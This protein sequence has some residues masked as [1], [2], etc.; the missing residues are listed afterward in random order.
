LSQLQTVISTDV[1]DSMEEIEM[2]TQKI[3][4]HLSVRLYSD[5]RPSCLETADLQKGLVLLFDGKELIEEGVGFGVPV[6]KY[7]DKT[8]FPGSAEIHVKKENS[9][10]VLTKTYSLNTVSLKKFGSATYIDDTLYSPLRKTFQTLYL[11]H[12]KLTPLFNKLME[13]RE[14]ANLK[15]EFIKVKPRG[16][17]TVSYRCLPNEIEVH[18]DFSNLALKRC[19]EILVLNEQGASFFPKYVDSNGLTLFGQKIGAW[20]TV[21]AK[22][23]TLQSVKGNVSFQLQNTG[24][25]RLFRGF[26]HTK[27]RFSWVGLSYSM[28]PHNR[29]FDYSVKLTSS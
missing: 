5:C 26:E 1:S 22:Q 28:H 4:A 21:L 25:A 27:K 15:T 13:L 17:V 24:G 9:E 10:V 2:F 3:S 19:S 23:S 20:E 29:T 16:Q 18:A 12:K 14:I 8:F 11:K 6:V 7:A